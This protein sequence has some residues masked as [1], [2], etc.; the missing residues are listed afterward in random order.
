MN[1]LCLCAV[2]EAVVLEERIRGERGGEEVG[3]EETGG[4]W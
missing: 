3:R 2:V 4:V 1:I